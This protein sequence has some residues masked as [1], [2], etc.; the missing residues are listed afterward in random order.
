MP[1]PSPGTVP[2]RT[3]GTAEPAVEIRGL[4]ASYR[5]VPVLKDVDAQ[6]PTGTLS[7]IVGPNGAGKST[8]LRAALGL[9]PADTGQ[10]RIAGAEGKAV[11]DHVAYV[12]QRESVDWD[13][14]ITVREVV[15]M[16]RY[17]ATGWFRRVG[18][19]DREIARDCLERVGMSAFA[20]RQI[21]QL[22]G[23][24]RQRVFLARALA[25]QASVLLM[26]EPFAGIDA[27]T[28]TD[29][30]TLLGELCRDGASVIVVHHA[31]AQVR[32]LFDWALLLN[33]QVLGCG[34]TADVL[35]DE[36]IHEAY[37]GPGGGTVGWV[38]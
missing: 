34:P 35:T 31:I 11:L 37:L 22:S 23:G 10:V 29:L 6:F 2:T 3:T 36:A 14:P 27:R 4:T 21:G 12:P 28:E 30:L 8:L 38:S 26:D 15:E 24:Q 20:R 32:A 9:I 18:R 17:R 7:A 16:G 5:Q 1:S 19:A 33:V 13:F 25:Q